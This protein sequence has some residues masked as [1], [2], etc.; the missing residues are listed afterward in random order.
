M[1]APIKALRVAADRLGQEADAILEHVRTGEAVELTSQGRAFA[2]ILP[3]GTGV[4][5]AVVEQRLGAPALRGLAR[6]ASD[7]DLF[8]TGNAWEADR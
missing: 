7:D 3:I 4:D 8:G 5:R 1:S 6:Y 2:L